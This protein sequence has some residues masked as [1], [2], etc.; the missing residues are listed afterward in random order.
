MWQGKCERLR[1]NKISWKDEEGKREI[2]WER[3]DPDEYW[4]RTAHA[5]MQKG[6]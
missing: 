1:K 2:K 6:I 4:W 5:C 3:A